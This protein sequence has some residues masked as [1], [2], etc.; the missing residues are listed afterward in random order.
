M[1]TLTKQMMVYYMLYCI[2]PYID[3]FF[4]YTWL[5]YLQMTQLI[6]CG[7]S[8]IHTVS[9]SKQMYEKVK[10]LSGSEVKK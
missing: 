2:P 3:F 8:H 9:S 10:V 5:V 6:S 4:Q 1:M 7:P